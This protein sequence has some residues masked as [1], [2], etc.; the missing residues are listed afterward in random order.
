MRELRFRY[1]TNWFN[2]LRNDTTLSDYSPVY[3]DRES[4]LEWYINFGKN[5]EK[6]FKRDLVL[7]EYYVTVNDF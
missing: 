6:T 7:V 1:K 2:P 3:K 4:A 5:L